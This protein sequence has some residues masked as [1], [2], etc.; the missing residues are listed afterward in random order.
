MVLLWYYCGIIVVLFINS[1]ELPKQ[2]V[3]DVSG[4][5]I[6]LNSFFNGLIALFH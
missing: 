3:I 2:E 4:T 6:I 1:K 5:K